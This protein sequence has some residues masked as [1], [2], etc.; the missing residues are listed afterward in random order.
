MEKN[1]INK[2][3][4]KSDKIN[5]KDT[6]FLILFLNDLYETITNNPFKNNKK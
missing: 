1:K 5:K 3:S 2:V 4:K 6:N